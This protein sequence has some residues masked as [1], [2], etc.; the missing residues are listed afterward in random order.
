MESREILREFAGKLAGLSAAAKVVAIAGAV[1]TMNGTL[2]AAG[3]SDAEEKLR[4]IE[5]ANQKSSNKVSDLATREKEPVKAQV[6]GA[7]VNTLLASKEKSKTI[8]SKPVVTPKNQVMKPVVASRFQIKGN[9]VKENNISPKIREKVAIYEPKKKSESKPKWDTR[10]YRPGATVKTPKDTS[11]LPAQRNDGMS[12]Y[13][14]TAISFVGATSDNEAFDG[15]K[16]YDSRKLKQTRT[17]SDT[18]PSRNTS[19]FYDSRNLQRTHTNS[20]TYFSRNTALKDNKTDGIGKGSVSTGFQKGVT[21]NSPSQPTGFTGF[22]GFGDGSSRPAPKYD[23]KTKKALE[24][25]GEIER[26]EKKLVTS[27]EEKR[28]IELQQ[29]VSQGKKKLVDTDTAARINEQQA[30]IA[31]AENEVR[32]LRN[33]L[34]I[35]RAE[36]LELKGRQG[37]L[38]H[39]AANFQILPQGG[40]N[41]NPQ[42]NVV[43]P[44]AQQMDVAQ[45]AAVPVVDHPQANVVPQVDVA[46]NAQPVNAQLQVN[47][48]VPPE[49]AVQNAARNVAT[50]AN[51]NNLQV[52]VGTGPSVPPPPPPP[53][54]VDNAGRVDVINENAIQPQVVAAVQ[55]S[56]IPP[57]PP[58]P[59]PPPGSDNTQVQFTPVATGGAVP[60]PPPPPPP[61]PG[62][63]GTWQGQGVPPPPPPPPGVP[64]PP[65]AQMAP[66]VVRQLTA[67]EKAKKEKEEMDALFA[68]VSE[69]IDREAVEEEKRRRQKEEKLLRE[70]SSLSA[71]TKNFINSIGGLDA[72][73]FNIAKGEY[74]KGIR[75][76]MEMSAKK[77]PY[78]FYDGFIRLLPTAKS[79]SEEDTKKF[80]T[81]KVL[82]EESLP[83]I[84][85]AVAYFEKTDPAALRAAWEGCKDHPIYGSDIPDCLADKYKKGDY[86]KLCGD[87]F[88]TFGIKLSGAR[89]DVLYNFAKMLVIDA[90]VQAK[91][92]TPDFRQLKYS[93]VAETV[94]AIIGAGENENV[95]AK[96]KQ[97]VES[98][99]DGIVK[100]KLNL[101]DANSLRGVFNQR[102]YVEMFVTLK[103]LEGVL[104][105]EQ[106][107]AVVAKKADAVSALDN[108]I[109]IALNLPSRTWYTDDEI[110]KMLEGHKA[111]FV[112][113]T[114]K[115]V[116]DDG[117]KQELLQAILD[118]NTYF[119]LSCLKDKYVNTKQMKD[120]VAKKS[121]KRTRLMAKLKTVKVSQ[122]IEAENE[123]KAEWDKGTKRYENRI[124]ALKENICGP[125]LFKEASDR[126]FFELLKGIKEQFEKGKRDYESMFYYPV[127]AKIRNAVA[128]TENMALQLTFADTE[129]NLNLMYNNRQI[130]GKVLKN[131]LKLSK[132]TRWELTGKWVENFLEFVLSES[133]KVTDLILINASFNDLKKLNN[134]KTL[135]TV[136]LRN[137]SLHD[138]ALNGLKLS[139]VKMN[140]VNVKYPETLYKDEGI[141][142]RLLESHVELNFGP[143]IGWVKDT[144]PVEAVDQANPQ[145]AVNG[146]PAG[147]LNRGLKKL[148]V[149]N[150]NN[151]NANNNN[152][153]GVQL[154]KRPVKQDAVAQRNTVLDEIKAIK[155]G[156]AQVAPEEL[157]DAILEKLRE[158]WEDKE[159]S[160]DIDFDLVLVYRSGNLE[161][162]IKKAAEYAARKQDGR[163][164]FGGDFVDQLRLDPYG[165]GHIVDSMGAN[166]VKAVK[167]AFTGLKDAAGWNA[168]YILQ[169][170]REKNV[171]LQSVEIVEFAYGS[172]L[173]VLPDL[174]LETL[175]FSCMKPEAWTD[176]NFGFNVANHDRWI[177]VLSASKTVDFSSCLFTEGSLND[178]KTIVGKM[179]P[180]NDNVAGNPQVNPQANA[181]PVLEKIILRNYQNPKLR[182]IVD[183]IRNLVKALNQ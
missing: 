7:P 149:G 97:E 66:M 166:G 116:L 163:I 152:G 51:A 140:F 173:D 182:K 27:I 43:Q 35:V 175:R 55:S 122:L 83:G 108:A 90:C 91:D 180:D 46:A 20:D 77:E 82:L 150:V 121:L 79:C 47:A 26:G 88:K 25:A 31:R 80:D 107:Q 15:K 8:E 158:L 39:Q 29:E 128:A 145:Q 109:F 19:K 18:Y 95:L 40:A 44:V 38:Q 170:F 53:P 63:V 168:D 138:K 167:F 84:L 72:N 65:G 131:A 159:E 148:P 21:P 154:K 94:T 54:F 89:G 60:P 99:S 113:E 110:T 130:I 48:A 24:I 58:P 86:Y 42:A 96:I 57:P 169:T 75:K 161:K 133:A 71:V 56:T 134:V 102:D 41:V 153:F 6:S 14:P 36:N 125:K 33:E 164:V 61:P 115:A 172:L 105:K 176:E 32:Q 112:D 120:A 34:Q 135:K 141:L 3:E 16:T 104:P 73:T 10:Y 30:N 118:Y 4:A 37:G 117:K 49:A 74:R 142:K 126:E 2:F 69:D 124:D 100:F 177:K 50:D 151:G 87:C 13:S 76:T 183:E 85:R 178:L 171:P 45:V 114:D 11:H 139:G 132:S 127:I 136:E 179:K 64:P 160:S 129:E 157:N 78:A 98:R 12:S 147:G 23:D 62:S 146:Q 1:S 28:A 9:Q 59:P 137:V 22:S 70:G 181:K 111:K 106:E 174:K 156:L 143:E 123:L 144:R 81:Y 52:I 165:V 67:E 119:L 155:A 93:E 101:E 17:N 162:T 92:A 68:N 103:T 5:P